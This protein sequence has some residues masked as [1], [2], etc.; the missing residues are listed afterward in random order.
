MVVLVIFVV[1]I[2][3]SGEY[4]DIVLMFSGDL[5]GWC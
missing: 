3:I 1:I 5:F 2:L 4:F